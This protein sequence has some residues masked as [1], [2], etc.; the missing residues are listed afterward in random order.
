[1]FG[2]VILIGYLIKKI[3][4]NSQSALNQQFAKFDLTASQTFIMIQLFKHH[5]K[6][7]LL[8]QKDLET[9]LQLSNPTV[10]GILKRLET[11]GLIERKIGEKDARVKYITLTPKAHQLDEEL[12]KVF[13]SHEQE[14]IKGLNEEEAQTLEQLLLQILTQQEREVEDHV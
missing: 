6:G 5:E 1:M 3:Y 7:I 14:L 10:T 13:A 11:K 12:K 8:N 4:W 9:A 2:G